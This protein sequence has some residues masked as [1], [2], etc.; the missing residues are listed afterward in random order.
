MYMPR[1][2]R[3]H[4]SASNLAIRGNKARARKLTL[5]AAGVLLVSGI[6]AVP[7]LGAEPPQAG[8]Q[9]ISF[10]QRD[11]VSASGY[12]Q[13]VDAYVQ[14]IRGGEPIAISTPV[15]PEDDPA[16][17]AFDGIVEVNHPGGG[18]WSTETGTP[19]IQPGDKIR[20]F[21]EQDDPSTP[22]VVDVIPVADDTTTTAS[23]TTGRPLVSGLTVTVKGTAQT[24]NTAGNPTGLPIPVAQIEQRL[25]NR[26]KFS[27]NGRRDLRAPRD[28][29]LRYDK[30]GSINWTATYTLKSST[31]V[32]KVNTSEARVLWLGANP[33]RGVE[34]TIYE[35]ATDIVAGPEA[36]CTAPLQGTT[37]TP[38]TAAA[39]AR[40]LLPDASGG[41]SAPVAPHSLIAFPSRDFISADGYTPGG[42]VSF[43]VLRGGTLVGQSDAVTVDEAG[44]AEV[45]HPGGGCWLADTQTPD[46]KVG[47]VVRI[48]DLRTHVAEETTVA[49]VVVGKPTSPAA[50][51]ATV[52]VTGTAFN[53]D[54]TIMDLAQV[55]QRF[56]NPARF[57]NGRRTLR[58]PGQGTL[59]KGA[60][61]GSW[62][63]TYTG[64]SPTDVTKALKGETRAMWLGS[65]PGTGTELTIYE[66]P[67]AQSGVLNG[68]MGGPMPPCT[69]PA[70][71]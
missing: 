20:V 46:V 30:A 67:D 1:N 43:S 59:E 19:D 68:V 60:T 66:L 18:C 15:Q 4:P 3:G 48:T 35:N 41:V 22:G 56:V 10:P 58:A 28:G 29:T 34:Q 24:L 17:A 37:A 62:V 47:D 53:T 9:V 44:V 12:V 52:T 8:H 40:A 61:P 42:S 14:V 71:G 38:Q 26:N 32:P 16:T 5:G 25:I 55:E 50:A 45:N 31:D 57:A 33:A 65:N 63:A 36:P 49:N 11:F 51:P 23:V 21:Q 2:N 64:L 70:E 69:A 13:G 39:P 54:G 7:A 6:A 27:F